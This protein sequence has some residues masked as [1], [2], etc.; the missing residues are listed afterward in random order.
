MKWPA[1]KPNDLASPVITDPLTFSGAVTL[2][3]NVSIDRTGGTTAAPRLLQF[4]NAGYYRVGSSSSGYQTG[5][6]QRLTLFNYWGI[7]L[8]GN[9]QA[10]APA[11]QGGFSTDASLRIVGTQAAAT[12]LRVEGAAAQTGSL[13]A[14]YD[15][16]GSMLAAIDS[17]GALTL[18]ATSIPLVFSGA[19]SPVQGTVGLAGSASLLPTAPTG[20]LK[21]KI[22]STAYVVPYYNAA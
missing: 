14:C 13:V 5:V 1:T 9:R 10:A 19:P 11:F 8:Y 16:G 20:Y 22:G 12:V 21:I 2:S 18:A 4:V 6:D 7:E 15:S 3:K 17:A